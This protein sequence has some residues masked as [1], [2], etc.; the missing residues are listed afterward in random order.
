MNLVRQSLPSLFTLGSLFCGLLSVVYTLD[1]SEEG[2][3][4]AAWLIIAAAIFDALDGKV[5][6]IFNTQSRFGVELDSI[7]DVCSF[8]FAPAVLCYQFTV[9]HLSG[10]QSMAFPVSFIFLACG[11]LRLAR[12]N[13]QLKGFDKNSYRGLPIPTAAGTVA[14]FIVF[15]KSDIMADVS[16][17]WV[18]PVLVLLVASLMVSTMKYDT[19]PRLAWGTTPNRVKLVILLVWLVFVA[20]YPAEAFFPLGALYVTFGLLRAGV[21]LL[22]GQRRV[23]LEEST[24]AAEST[25]RRRV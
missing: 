1:G 12:F 13:V 11:A 5:S 23:A 16:V 24:A 3:I 25:D 10:W 9:S 2:L 6:R 19:L 20:F 4:T 7:V 8:G 17:E 22:R 21:R 14:A 15:M 18:L